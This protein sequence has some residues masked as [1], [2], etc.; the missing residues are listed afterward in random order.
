MSLDDKA[1]TRGLSKSL[2]WSGLVA[3]VV[4]IAAA[5]IID[6]RGAPEI[7]IFAEEPKGQSAV[8]S[9]IIERLFI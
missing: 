4:S 8:P 6:C 9:T 2:A 1:A 5:E 7:L 3:L